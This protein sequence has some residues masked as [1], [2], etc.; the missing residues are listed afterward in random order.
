[1][2]LIKITTM[3]FYIFDIFNHIACYCH[4]RT[5]QYLMQLNHET[6]VHRH[7]YVSYEHVHISYIYVAF[8]P[9]FRNIT[10]RTL[11][12]FDRVHQ[13]N[14]ILEKTVLPSHLHTC[15]AQQVQLQWYDKIISQHNITDVQWN[16]ELYMRGVYGFDDHTR[17]QHI[18]HK[19]SDYNAPG[20][21]IMSSFISDAMFNLP[22]LTDLT[23]DIKMRHVKE[24]NV[25]WP[26][27]LERLTLKHIIVQHLPC[28]LKYFHCDVRA[29]HRMIIDASFIHLRELI[30]QHHH[31][32]HFRIP[33]HE[34]T[35]LKRLTLHWSQ[36]TFYLLPASLKYFETDVIDNKTMLSQMIN[37]RTLIVKEY[38]L[39]T[40]PDSLKKFSVSSTLK[41]CQL[42]ASLTYLS[43][44]CHDYYF[45][46]QQ[47]LPRLKTLHLH[48]VEC[49]LNMHH[50]PALHELHCSNLRYVKN[51][52]DSQLQ[53]LHV[54]YYGQWTPFP[55]TLHT[56]RVNYLDFHTFHCP[57]HIRHFYCRNAH[58]VMITQR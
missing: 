38:A 24:L 9:C 26:F 4:Y 22:C 36:N 35:N 47:H 6:F 8:T 28:T 34:L 19:A 2:I 58:A 13:L 16:D 46:N 55:E 18:S 10:C 42:P 25:Q 49:V 50:F 12:S 53:I 27:A 30:I 39:K 14:L 31:Y 7:H 21:L 20:K 54:D 41:Q 37:V 57:V 3:V 45:F 43:L 29:P 23:L 33:F 51:L 17:S 40:F 48:T 44:N 15:Q 11:P 52:M 1:M 32:F 56:F 5:V